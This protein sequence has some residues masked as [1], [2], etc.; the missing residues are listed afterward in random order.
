MRGLG[1]A[2]LFLA[3]GFVA[4]CSQVKAR[5]EQKSADQFAQTAFEKFRVRGIRQLPLSDQYDEMKIRS[6]ETVVKLIPTV[7]PTSSR[8][9]Q[10]QI[11]SDNDALVRRQYVYPDRKLE[12]SV[13]ME[14]N[15]GFGSWKLYGLSVTPATEA[16]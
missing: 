2:I 1:I 5:F 9:T 3:A 10:I 8:L 16:R 7:K 4:G 12:V 11:V 13:G 14:R 15:G 6:A